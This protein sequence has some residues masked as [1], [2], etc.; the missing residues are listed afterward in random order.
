M[1]DYTQYNIRSAVPQAYFQKNRGINYLIPIAGG[2]VES[3]VYNPLMNEVDRYDV[4][5]YRM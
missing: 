3:L 2:L 4:M 5:Y 1:F